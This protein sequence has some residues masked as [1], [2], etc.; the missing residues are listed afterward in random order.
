MQGLYL[1]FL[2]LLKNIDC[3]YSIRILPITS[4][5]SNNKKN[6]KLYQ[7]DFFY[8]YRFQKI[9]YILVHQNIKGNLKI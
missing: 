6:I 3:G 1:F 7:L 9:L 8:F 5:L 2:I 4:V